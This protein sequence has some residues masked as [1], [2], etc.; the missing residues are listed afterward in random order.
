MIAGNTAALYARYARR[1]RSSPESLARRLKDSAITLY[2]VALYTVN[3]L[4]MDAVMTRAAASLAGRRDDEFRDFCA[5]FVDEEVAPRVYPAARDEIDACRR[6]GRTVAL[7]SA[8]LD[9][10]VRPLA[11]A[12]GIDHVF[13]TTLIVGETGAFTGGYVRPPCYGAGKLHYAERFCEERALSLA[14]S[15]FYTDSASDLPLL[16]RVGEPRP[17]NADWLLRREARRR[18]WTVLAFERP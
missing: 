5:R 18:G 10:V 6:A 7:L 11:R 16:E 12:L 17:V 2:Y 3:R 13:A 15:A 14:E 4:D 8:S 9:P 1:L